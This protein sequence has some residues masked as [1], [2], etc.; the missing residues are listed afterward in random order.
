MYSVT[1]I[2][3]RTLGAVAT[4]KAEYAA[5]L[6][7]ALRAFGFLARVWRDGTLVN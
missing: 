2:N 4:P 5:T 6:V 3:G 7:F 1:W